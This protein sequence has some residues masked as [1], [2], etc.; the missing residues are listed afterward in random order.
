MK[1]M[2]RKDSGGTF[3]DRMAEA[4]A[5]EYHQALTADGDELN[6]DYSLEESTIEAEERS[7]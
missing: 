4:S 7:D 5:A 3:W 1:A 6:E 2:R